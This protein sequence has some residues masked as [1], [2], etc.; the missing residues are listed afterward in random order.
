M[1]SGFKIPRFRTLVVCAIVVACVAAVARGVAAWTL[2]AYSINE[3]SVDVGHIAT[4]LAGETAQSIKAL[5]RSLALL[6]RQLI[7]R[8][9]AP[10]QYDIASAG[11]R[12][13][14]DQESLLPGADFAIT[15]PQGRVVE[16]SISWPDTERDVSTR[17]FF[18]AQRTGRDIFIGAA[19]ARADLN[20]RVLFLS[21]R[22]ESR[23]GDFLGVAV[24]RV[25]AD[26][27]K[28]AYGASAAM[29]NVAF[30]LVRN[31]GTVLVRD[32]LPASQADMGQNDVDQAADTMSPQSPWYATL[33]GGGG[34]Y[35]SADEIDHQARFVGVSAV[36][37]Y[38]LVVDASELES[39]VMAPW[40]RLASM[41]AAATLLS[42]ITFALLLWA[43]RVQ[44]RNLGAAQASLAERESEL[45]QQ[46]RELASAHT[47][48]DAALNNMSQGLCMFDK[49]E[50]LLVRNERYLRIYG[51]Q[52]DAAKPGAEF[53][54]V[55][56]QQQRAGNFNGDPQQLA[57][58]LRA[59]LAHGET[60]NTIHELADGR[61]IE[62]ANEPVAGGGWVATYDDV[63]ERQRSEARIAHLARYDSLTDLANRMLFR[64]KADA[65]L[66]SYKASGVGYSIFIFDLDL[67]KS[68]NDSLGHPVGDALLKAVAT[69]LKSV[70]GTT[71]TVGR[72]G[73]D[74]FA[75][76][77]VASGDQREGAATLAARLLEVIAAPYEIDGH[78]I[79]IG[80]S[81]GIA[82]APLHGT[83]NE[84]L[85]KSADLAL[86]RA[87]SDGRNSYR[88]F[89]P[90]MD[91]E[92]QLRR[93][94]EANLHGAVANGEFEAYYQPLID[95][96]DRRICS[97][98][99]LIRWQHPGHGAVAPGRFI[100][101]AEERG[102]IT[103]IDRW[104]VHRACR[105]AMAWPEHIG[106]A[107]N[108]SP[109]EF[110][111]GDLLEMITDALD[112][113]GLPASRLELEITESVLLQKSAHNLSLLHEIRKLG[114]SIVLDDFGTGYSS[115]GYLR[116]FP[117]DKIKI[118]QS[119][120][121]EMPHRADCAAI[122]CAI[123]NLGR[124][125][126]MVTV[127]EGVETSEQLE[128]VR[129]AGCKQAQGF[130]F[131]RPVPAAQLRFDDRVAPRRAAWA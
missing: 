31:D 25:R 47:Q 94:L 131:S 92:V 33:A 66:E 20:E 79:V 96:A 44:F 38:P 103:A 69:R 35:R 51:M 68:V 16:H 43:L 113:S 70:V 60:V 100:P 49:D 122:V 34:A 108:L 22:A 30:A 91:R 80:T 71:D 58:E 15:D 48:I 17:K 116:L 83:E 88:F 39:L 130:L 45:R 75:V 41:I 89:E 127:A 120:V 67:F 85:L 40:Q 52:S 1:H 55:L 8:N 28:P 46:S 114:V 62:V 74:E 93:T 129:A 86:Y 82:M 95:A 77:H 27:F 64:E 81:V 56:T 50:R 118:D 119:F 84:K 4:A 121:R 29:E 76:L 106:V 101:L 61:I 78:H 24:I 123:A 6:Q 73:G 54:D 126:N 99:A 26:Y 117:F 10:D 104:M 5:D 3:A 125:L 7:D 115:L 72:L 102:L 112:R 110:R 13:V 63:T 9:A 32:P 2:R 21:R 23:Q 57:D 107:V 109:I 65:A 11:T 42:L 18:A 36:P 53:V 87:K 90:E 97:V 12:P 128:L 37:G 111:S 124:E 59:R 105:D 19:D 14:L 98:E